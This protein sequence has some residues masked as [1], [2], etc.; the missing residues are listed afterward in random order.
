M[1]SDQELDRGM[2]TLKIIWLAML[3]S[4]VVYLFVG[5]Y[6]GTSVQLSINEDSLDIL[7]VILYML[8]FAILMATRIVRRLILE[9]K[10]HY[11]AGT[12]QT[13]ALQRY[14]TAMIVALTMS[15]TMGIFGLVLF[16][17]GKNPMDL[18]L[19]VAVSAAAMIMYRPRKEEIIIPAQEKPE[20]STAGG[21]IS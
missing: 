17:L 10:R 3:M 1:I 2:L 12:S 13:S 9:G 7:K 5:L 11:A 4:L 6:V 20:D 14:L 16:L 15:E 8:S 21:A 19:L 18:Y